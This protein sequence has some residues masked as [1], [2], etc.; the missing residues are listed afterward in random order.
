[1]S[2]PR[3]A[4]ETTGYAAQEKDDERPG[5]DRVR[6][7]PADETVHLEEAEARGRDDEGERKEDRDRREGPD[8]KERGEPRDGG[9]VA[10]EDVAAD[11][12][13]DGHEHDA[14]ASPHVFPA[15]HPREGEEV[16]EDEEVDREREDGDPRL[17]GA[18]WRGAP[19]L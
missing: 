4:G 18:S 8:G 2:V 6:G 12:D 13:E 9:N 16:D 15:R 19:S 3:R 14:G 7:A 11:V 17:P 1:M 10:K 5:G